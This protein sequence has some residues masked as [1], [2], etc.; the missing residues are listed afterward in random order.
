MIAGARFFAGNDPALDRGDDL[1]LELDTPLLGGGRRKAAAR[2]DV[3]IGAYDV[4]HWRLSI[5]SHLAFLR[6][7]PELTRLSRQ[8][9]SPPGRFGTITLG[10][11]E[12][13]S[14][15]SCLISVATISDVFVTQ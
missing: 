6:R 1:G 15:K 7:D 11:F 14:S 4:N 2:Y 8:S 5:F 3:T 13:H 9:S 10:S 12:S